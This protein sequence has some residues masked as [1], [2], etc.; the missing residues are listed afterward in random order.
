M[1]KP[2][3]VSQVV[4]TKLEFYQIRLKYTGWNVLCIFKASIEVSPFS[5]IV[6]IKVWSFLYVFLLIQQN[7]LCFK[8]FI[9]H[10]TLYFSP[11]S[12]M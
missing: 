4:Q 9:F 3:V 1:I 12:I 5:K 2:C 11:K 7:V 6:Q 8:I 10:N